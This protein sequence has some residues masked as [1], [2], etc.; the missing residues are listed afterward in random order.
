MDDLLALLHGQVRIPVVGDKSQTEV[1]R[2]T[3]HHIIFLDVGAEQVNA[4]Q[5]W[6]F[7]FITS[8]DEVVV[9][10]ILFVSSLVTQRSKVVGILF[11]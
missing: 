9:E 1:L 10:G 2:E 5:K 7:V 8:D 11:Y 4:G 6:C 3:S